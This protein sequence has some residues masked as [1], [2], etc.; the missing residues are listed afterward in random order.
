MAGTRGTVAGWAC[1]CTDP[2]GTPMRAR[3]WS[4]GP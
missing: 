4:R 2:A 3:S 1:R